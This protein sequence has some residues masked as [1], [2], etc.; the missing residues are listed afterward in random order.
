MR[1]RANLGISLSNTPICS[2]S[3]NKFQ[4]STKLFA[5]TSEN[6]KTNS[7]HRITTTV[8]TVEPAN[9]TT[10]QIRH[11]TT[12]MALT[13]F[14]KNCQLYFSVIYL[15]LT[16]PLHPIHDPF[17]PTARVHFFFEE[18]ATLLLGGLPLL[19]SSRFFSEDFVF[20]IFFRVFNLFSFFFQSSFFYSECE[21]SLAGFVC[22]GLCCGCLFCFLLSVL[23][24]CIQLPFHFF[25]EF[26]AVYRPCPVHVTT[27]QQ[28]QATK[29][30]IPTPFS[31]TVP[32][33]FPEAD[34]P[35][36]STTPP[37]LTLSRSITD[38]VNIASL[39]AN[40]GGPPETNSSSPCLLT[41]HAP[42]WIVRL[43][44]HTVGLRP[45]PPPRLL[46][47]TFPFGVY[48]CRKPTLTA[49]RRDGI[50]PTAS[51]PAKATLST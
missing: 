46:C 13:F 29:I 20:Q 17:L 25:C 47:P 19:E 33:F 5:S 49:L 26:L 34:R 44:Q 43:L 21:I 10:A 35:S 22:F 11:R 3:K 41:Y 42:C 30:P 8:S 6:T 1:C 23:L 31:T 38:A 7:N 50:H 18:L 9:Q 14:S 15:F 28:Y 36:P 16:P 24:S 12:D 27:G 2:T 39:S 32:M 51:P 4:I 37:F 45:L 40:I 48:F